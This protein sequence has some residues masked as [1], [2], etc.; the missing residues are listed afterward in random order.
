MAVRLFV[1]P[2][3]RF[4]VNFVLPR[5]DL[6]FEPNAPVWADE[7]RLRKPACFFQPPQA[8]VAERNNRQHLFFIEHA[9][10]GFWCVSHDRAQSFQMEESLSDGVSATPS[11]LF[12]RAGGDLSRPTR[13]GPTV[14]ET[15][16]NALSN[17]LIPQRHD[18][19]V[20]SGIVRAQS[21][22]RGSG[23]TVIWDQS[24]QEAA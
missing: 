12:V 22:Q 17:Q 23:L 13:Q 16:E 5:H 4:S 14:A 19:A 24:P 21:D 10:G 11:R 2:G 6:V 9:A 20:I 1:S 7:S 3:S 18:F 8:G 15:T